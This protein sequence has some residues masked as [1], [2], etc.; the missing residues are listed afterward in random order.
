VAGVAEMSLRDRFVDAFRRR[1]DTVCLL[2]YRDAG[3]RACG[4]T[5]TAVSSVSAD[6]PLL[7]ACVNA[8]TR[9][10]EAIRDLGRF[11]VNL[12]SAGQQHIA[13]SC[14]RPGADKTLDPCWLDARAAGR[15]PQLSGSVAYLDCEVAAAHEH[16]THVVFIGLVR[17]A[18]VNQDT[19]PLVYFDGGYEQVDLVARD[20]R[21]EV[22][23]VS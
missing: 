4:M 16:G 20:P 22:W 23:W 13:W 15:P 21:A 17:A 2:T 14:A 1:A 18:A 3:G 11:G 6:P 9:T 8:R 12:L 10:C 19:Y 5:A 7:C